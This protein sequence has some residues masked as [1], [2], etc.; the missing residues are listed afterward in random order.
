MSWELQERTGGGYTKWETEDGD[1]RYR[2]PE[3]HG[4]SQQKFAGSKGGEAS[5]EKYDWEKDDDGQ[6]TGGVEEEDEDGGPIDPPVRPNRRVTA[7][8]NVDTDKAR[9]WG[10]T[11]GSEAK[12]EITGV[13]NPFDAPDNDEILDI[14]QELAEDAQTQLPFVDD[15]PDVSIEKAK[16]SRRAT[17]WSG[18]E[19]EVSFKGRSGGEYT[20]TVDPKQSR[21]TDN[22]WNS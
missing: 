22:R 5:Q 4:A 19:L 11:E 17:G 13:F 10:G 18:G 14:M 12:I 3:G 6:F 21:I 20:Y 8:I 2:S 9:G 16:T 1:T 15:E 7:T